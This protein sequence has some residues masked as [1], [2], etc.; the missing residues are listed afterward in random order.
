MYTLRSTFSS[1]NYLHNNRFDIKN[2]DEFSPALFEAGENELRHPECFCMCI[3]AEELSGSCDDGEH[4]WYAYDPQER[5]RERERETE[6]D[7]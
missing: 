3:L 6:I 1:P 7:D 5:K 2:Y 4:A